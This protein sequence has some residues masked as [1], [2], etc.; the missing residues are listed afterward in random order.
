M[1]ITVMDCFLVIVVTNLSA[2]INDDEGGYGMTI[3]DVLRRITLPKR[4]YSNDFVFADRFS[5]EAQSFVCFLKQCTGEEFSDAK[6]NKVQG[7]MPHLIDMV[8]QT[9]QSI[10]NAIKA[11]ESANPKAAQEEFDA[12]M[13]RMKD[14]LFFCT[15][16]DYVL[17]STK[18]RSVCT[19]FRITPGNR[20]YRVRPVNSET[21]S[22][23]QSPDE[24]FHVPYLKR[25]HLTNERFSLAGFPSLYLSTMLPLAWQECAYP[26]KYYYSEFAYNYSY[27][28]NFSERVIKDDLLFLALYS[29]DEICTWGLAE[30]YN[31]FD[32]WLEVIT[33]YLESFP[34]V[35]ACSFVNQSGKVPYKQEYIVSQMLM[36]WVQ[37]NSSIARGISYFTCV[38]TSMW[39]RCWCAYNVVI[40]A[41][42]PYDG[43]GYSEELRERFFWTRPQ[44]Y[45]VP[46]ADASCCESDCAYVYQFLSDVRSV[47]RT[48]KFPT[49]I[50]ELLDRMMNIGICL[51]S[52]LESGT[53][54]NMQHALHVLDS[55]NDNCKYLKSIP[56]T[57]VI[58]DIK[59]G[60]NGFDAISDSDI[61]E[62][63][64]CIY[65]L[66]NDVICCKPRSICIESIIDKYK[67]QCWNDLS[68]HS[69]VLIL[70]HNPANIA[71]L[72]KWLGDR[73]IISYIR[74]LCP[75]DKSAQY[76]REMAN[77]THV[78]ID[79]FWGKAVGDDDWIKAN[80]YNIREPILI[81]QNDISIFSPADTKASELIGIGFDKNHLAMKLNLLS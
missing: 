25:A 51:L 8:E 23:A 39:T 55:I 45:T 49:D 22:I 46:I 70:F 53:T 33:R 67:S 10:Q 43:K 11:F 38:D 60:K 79:D 16:D 13:S 72:R 27:S 20:F 76:L 2:S 71:E 32:L 3:E 40:P 56:L 74:P 1:L 7:I 4:Y 6:R 42:P 69:N 36:Q 52:L 62:A 66:F 30:K 12:L 48:M 28:A 31:D 77:K 81:K 19:R 9:I 58:D 26:S 37:R 73:H 64:T 14:D 54:Q 5:D 34:L 15:I 75:D 17:V 57:T 78:S 61:E 44:F 80:L 68:P 29:P 63:C 65:K 47:E 21:N 59:R 24:L 18:E 41:A 35:M 50:Y